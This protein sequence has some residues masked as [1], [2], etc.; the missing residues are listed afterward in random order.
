MRLSKRLSVCALSLLL[1]ACAAK[2]IPTVSID[3]A[4][5]SFKPIPNSKAAP[6][7]MQKAVA[8]HNSVLATHQTGKETIYKAPC[9]TDKPQGGT[10]QKVASNAR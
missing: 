9:E 3:G 10:P 2:E 6:C 4:I 7:V 8:E 1:P 5:R